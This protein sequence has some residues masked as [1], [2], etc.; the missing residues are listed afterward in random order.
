MPNPTNTLPWLV[1]HVMPALAVLS[2][3]IFGALTIV[4]HDQTL[5]PY[6]YQHRGS[7]PDH[8]GKPATPAPPRRA[9]VRSSHWPMFFS[10][11]TRCRAVGRPRGLANFLLSA[12]LQHGSFDE[13]HA[14]M[15]TLRHCGLHFLPL[16]LVLQHARAP[17]QFVR[18][19]VW[20]LSACA[21]IVVWT[22]SSR[23]P[24]TCGS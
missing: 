21:W 14:F 6:Q 20:T 13:L 10:C 4:Q 17:Q 2:L 12:R 24:A 23:G 11:L 3:R 8:F 19:R 9:H 5:Q 7:R 1:A 16:A 22:L 15:T 18:E